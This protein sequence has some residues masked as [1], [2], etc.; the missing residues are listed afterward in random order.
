M[1]GVTISPEMT[2]FDITEKFP[3]TVEVFVA[4]GFEQVGD[5]AKQKTQGRMVTLAQAVQMKK[6]DLPAFKALLENAV[7]ENRQ[8]EDV[9][10][11]VVSDED[12]IFPSE[13]D[14][15][16]AGLL[17]CP[18][19]LPLLEAFDRVSKEITA[20][21]GKTVGVR[22]AAASIGADILDEGMKSIETKE[23]LPDLF[24]SAGFEAFFDSKNMARFKDQ[25][26]FTDNSWAKHNDLLGPYGLKDPDG[27]Y[28]LLAV[29]PAV[30]LVDKTQL[31]EDQA[32]P[33]TWKEILGPE[34]EGR[35][36]MPVGD[37]DLFNGI[38][39]TVWKEFGEDGVRAVG[40]NLL[41][42]MHPSQ[43]AGRFA[44]KGGK[45]PLVSVI[46]YFFS[47]MAQ[48]NPNAEIVWPEDGAVISPIFMLLKESAPPEARRL[49]DF[50]AS[51]E[52]GEI[53]S[54]RGLFPSCH[55]EVE[56]KVPDSAP[57]MWLGWDFIREHD[58]GELI[59]R[60]NEIF[61]EAGK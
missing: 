13:G 20:E 8:T 4:N 19:R 39:L 54:H 32:V 56:N 15:R 31:A 14:I 6:K 10:L 35:I 49:A 9:T 59:P 11:D 34:F 53:L 29:V 17:P 3:E 41:E 27:H 26:V 44:P 18:V 45:G 36:A 2:L 46:P 43:A 33:R 42:G 61:L 55:P 24:L 57:F 1:S 47:K 40:R 25:G 30:F 22:L 12:Q 38:L 60:V 50:F 5:K 7:R 28:A 51:R 23:D 21:T 52:V 58:L 48:F 37:F 16:V